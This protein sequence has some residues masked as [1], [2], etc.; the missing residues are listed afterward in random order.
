ME[1][2]IFSVSAVAPIVLMVLIGYFLKRLGMMNEQF[3][4]DANKLVFR[5]FMPVMLFLNIYKI[6][7]LSGFNFGFIGYVLIAL[8]IIFVV[9]IPAVIA[10]TKDKGRRGVLVQAAF[11]SGYSLI[12]IPL[13]ESLYGTEGAIAATLLSAG[14]IPLFNI[15]AVISLSMFS[16]GEGEKEKISIKKILIGIVKNPLII[17]IAAG[18][19]ALG[20]RAIFESCGIEFRLGNITPVMTVIQYVSN[21]AIPMALLVLGAQF[22]FAAVASMKNEIIFGTVIRTVVVPA[23]FVSIAYFFFRGTFTAAHYACFVSVFATPVAVPTVPMAQ[24]MDGDVTLAGQLVVWST[25]VSAVTVF[26]VTFLLKIGG[27]F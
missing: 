27:A 4:K 18:L 21:L 8:L 24:E 14:V 1:S 6:K 22:E 5:V 23:I 25:L 2:F 12:G 3:A 13:A 26:L 9:S 15:L 11:R 20:I 19:A 17:G 7:D 16:D 10:V